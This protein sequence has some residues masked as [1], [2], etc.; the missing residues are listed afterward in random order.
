VKN[1]TVL[2]NFDPSTDDNVR[3]MDEA[4]TCT[5]ASAATP[6]PHVNVENTQWEFKNS[7][8]YP[9]W[10]AKEKRQRIR[11]DPKPIDRYDPESSLC[12]PSAMVGVFCAI[13]PQVL[14]HGSFPK[15]VNLWE[16]LPQ[17]SIRQTK[18]PPWACQSTDLCNQSARRLS[19]RFG[20]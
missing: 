2:S 18:P 20:G 15:T 13:A 11:P 10:D 9:H 5:N 14:E 8:Q 19:C 7:I 3:R 6:C 1:Q 4:Q 17:A 12:V 16:M